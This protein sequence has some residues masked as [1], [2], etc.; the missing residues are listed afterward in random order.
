MLIFHTTDDWKCSPKT[1]RG[2]ILYITVWIKTVN[3]KPVLVFLKTIS[4]I[5]QRIFGNIKKDYVQKYDTLK[6]E[7]LRKYEKLTIKIRNAELHATF[8]RT[9][10]TFNATHKFLIINLPNVSLYDLQFIS[11]SRKD[12]YKVHLTKETKSWDHLREIY[13]VMSGKLKEYC[14]PLI[15]LSW[16]MLS[17][18]TEI[19]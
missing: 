14:H 19:K 18:G 15:S 11:S 17:N 4:L 1:S 9:C 12:Y 13:Q 5:V 3:F 7:Q 10:Q 8:L 6:I 16:T 2:L